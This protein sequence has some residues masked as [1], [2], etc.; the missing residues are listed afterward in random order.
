[1]TYYYD[2][3]MEGEVQVVQSIHDPV[4][5]IRPCPNCG[6]AARRI[7]GNVY[8]QEDRLRMRKTHG[9]PTDNWS[10]ALHGPMPETRSERR[11]IEK[12]K[13]ISFDTTLT[14]NEK[15]IMDYRRHVDETGDHCL[16]SE[17]VNPQHIENKPLQ[18]YMDRRGFRRD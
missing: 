4:P 13:G 6:Y 12:E 2:C 3:Q 17:Q 11:R 16:T 1:M 10:F 9:T 15:R 5:Q 18:W 14:E 8:F 7:Y